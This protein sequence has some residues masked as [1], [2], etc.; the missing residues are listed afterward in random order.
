MVADFPSNNSDK[1]MAILDTKVWK[2]AD[3]GFIMYEHYEKAVANKD[4][5]HAQSAQSASCKKNVHIQQVLRRML[6]TSSRLNWEEHGAPFVTDYMLRMKNAEYDKAYRKNILLHASRVY[7]KKL[8]DSQSGA[9]PIYRE[10]TMA[11]N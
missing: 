1:K 7:S 8:E 6:N 11:E 3:K 10:K 5:L 4:V 9:G 2:C